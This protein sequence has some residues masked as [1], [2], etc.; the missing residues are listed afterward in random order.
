MENEERNPNRNEDGTY[1]PEG[2]GD[3]TGGP[4]EEKSEE[5]SPKADEPEITHEA[6]EESEIYRYVSEKSKETDAIK[7]YVDKLNELTAKG[8]EPTD[9]ELDAFIKAD[10]Y[11]KT[12]ERQRSMSNLLGVL[13]SIGYPYDKWSQNTKNHYRDEAY[14]MP[15][16]D[17]RCLEQAEGF[18]SA[19]ISRNDDRELDEAG[20]D[21]IATRED[22]SEECIDLKCPSDPNSVIIRLSKDYFDENGDIQ[23][24]GQT[25]FAD[26]K[27]TM[28]TQYAFIFPADQPSVDE[29]YATNHTEIDD[30]G[31]MDDATV[32]NR[33][34]DYLMASSQD[35]KRYIFGNVMPEDKLREHVR[36]FREIAATTTA[37]GLE[38][39]IDAYN[40]MMQ[41]DGTGRKLMPL[42]GERGFYMDIEFAHKA[43][44]DAPTGYAR[45]M[46][47]IDDR[48]RIDVSLGMPR[49]QAM[50]HINGL[51][52]NW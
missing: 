30:D 6:T 33:H 19:S 38:G 13:E 39:E 45:L 3:L 40:K 52:Y 42:P 23:T 25:V 7:A 28:T 43:E 50:G 20:V 51:K 36:E 11:I 9:G 27:R 49:R 5:P 14:S 12:P 26:P 2:T 17:F 48:G 15:L 34:G 1:A 37:E 44:K 16:F 8:Y 32:Y 31:T 22:G 46:A 4:K 47:T 21:Y 18:L 29:I 24:K 41:Y 35:M 10:D